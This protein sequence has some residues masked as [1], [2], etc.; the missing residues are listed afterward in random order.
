MPTLQ[1]GFAVVQALTHHGGTGRI[2]RYG[3][4]LWLANL[5]RGK[6]TTISKRRTKPSILQ[7]SV[8]GIH[9]ILSAADPGWF[10][11]IALPFAGGL[12][13]WSPVGAALRYA[14]PGQ[15]TMKKKT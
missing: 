6:S 13:Y 4:M 8:S 9:G 12:C 10:L 3:E 11:L 2:T 15:G 7:V 14:S 1:K 5:L